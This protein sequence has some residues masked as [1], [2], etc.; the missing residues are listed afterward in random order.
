MT[1]SRRRAIVRD[2]SDS[3]SKA[4]VQDP[5]ARPP[6]VEGAIEQHDSVVE[7]LE[8]L[9]VAVTRL[10]AE[11]SLPDAC[12][13]DDLA[14]ISGGIALLTLPGAPQ[15]RAERRAVRAALAPHMP[16]V[17]MEGP[18]TLDGGDV[19]EVGSTFLVG[20][21]S[22]TNEAGI[23]RLRQTF[24]PLGR[25]VIDVAVGE[26]LHLMSYA[27]A[28]RP[29]LVVMAPGWLDEHALPPGVDVIEVIESERAAANLI[30]VGDKVLCP[31][32]HPDTVRR[33]GAAGLEVIELD[34]S[35][36]ATRDGGL[37]CLALF[38]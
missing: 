37:T 13:V 36:I 7:A 33:L 18:A 10:D 22:R 16:I 17:A 11:D 2:V 26:G 5:N 19:L 24:E 20:K 3:F 12:F 30:G 15:R 14:V 21:S 9:G 31:A 29:D 32:G 35:E 25:T 27:S 38:F 8:G 6:R 23:H 28:P 1:T 4:L 34:I